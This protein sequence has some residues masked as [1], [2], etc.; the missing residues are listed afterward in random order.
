MGI[1]IGNSKIGG[2]FIGASEIAKIYQGS[3][4]IFENC[5]K[6]P[7]YGYTFGENYNQYLIGSNSTSGVL[8]NVTL[9]TLS[10][11]SGKLGASGSTIK[12]TNSSYSSAGNNSLT[13]NTTKTYNGVKLYVYKYQ[14]TSSYF[15]EYWHV[16][17]IEDAAVGS[18]CIEWVTAIDDYINPTSVGSNSMTVNSSLETTTFDRKSSIDTTFSRNGF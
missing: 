12:V 17:V 8:G 16:Y 7:A 3:T 1:N 10:T 5:K 9:C 2:V 6:I 13:Y 15:Y 14:N 18:K 11:V 4:L